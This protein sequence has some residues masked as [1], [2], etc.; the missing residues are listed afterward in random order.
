MKDIYYK[1]TTRGFA[2]LELLLVAI[3]IVSLFFITLKF[4]V[5]NPSIDKE[6]KK[7]LSEQGIDT[8]SQ[9]AILDST[10]AKVEELNKQML[11]REK[12]LENF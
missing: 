8:S 2:L 11:N 10:K 6:T 5:K 1:K 3:L 12:Q 7:S 4:Y 9:K